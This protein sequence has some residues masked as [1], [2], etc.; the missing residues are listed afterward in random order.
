MATGSD[1][2]YR[3]CFRF[4]MLDIAFLPCGLDMLPV[5]NSS[6]FP[7][8]FSSPDEAVGPARRFPYSSVHMNGMKRN[9]LLLAACQALLVTGLSLLLATSA[10]VGYRLSP[11]KSLATLPLAMQ[12]LAGMLTSIPASFFMQRFGRRTGFLLGSVIGITG[13]GVATI[14][15]VTGSFPLFVFSAV[16]MG[17]FVG[18]VNFYRFAAAD[19]ATTEYRS[20]AISYVMAGGVIAAFIGPNLAHWTS[21]W[22]IAPF[23]GSYLA[24]VGILLL[25]FSVQLFLDIPHPSRE[26]Q[27]SGRKLGVIVRQPAFIVAAIGGMLGYGI[28]SLVMTATPLAMHDHD[29]AFSDTAFVIEWHLLGMFVPSFFSGHLIRRIGVL[30]V[31]LVGGLLSAVC[32]AIN[33]AGTSLSHFWLALFLLGVGWN[34]LFIGATTLLTETYVPEEKAKIQALNDFLVFGTVT[35]SVLSAGSLQHHLGWR[36]VNF[37]VMPLIVVTVI[38]VVWL[39]VSRRS[40]IPVTET[41]P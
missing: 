20:T 17:M 28:M 25:S 1:D 29:H 36:A 34:F 39:L 2:G 40:S 14:A 5:A 31:M 12:M 3:G 16:L 27:G 35:L 21:S 18:F 7:E 19:A 24:L 22:L 33:L 9:V 15:T 26:L 30:Q 38:A 4:S 32:V 10:L 6:L 13:A 41:L 23:A 8:I 11:D 37:G